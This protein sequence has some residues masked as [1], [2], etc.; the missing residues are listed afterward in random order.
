MRELKRILVANRG[1]IACRIMRTCAA[2]GIETVAVWSEAD[3]DALHVSLADAAVPIGPAPA[4]QSYLDQEK[5]LDAARCSGAD[6][7]HPGYGFLSESAAFARA[8]AGSGLAWIGPAPDTIEAMG[9]KERARVIARAVGV[10]V[11]P[12][13]ERIA[14][15]EAVDPTRIGATIG[16]PLLVKAAAGGGGIGM[17]AVADPGQLAAQVEKTQSLAGRAFTD[18]TV[19]LE[20]YVP[21]ARH[22]EVQVF[23]AGDGRGVHLFDRDCTVQRRFQKVIEEAPAP[24]IPDR[25]RRAMREAAIALVR[26]E[27]YAGA[28]TVEFI[29]DR[30]RDEFYF[31][32][33]NTRIQVEHAVSEMVTGVDLVRWQIEQAAGRFNLPRQD[34]LCCRGHALECRLY[35][36]RPEKNFLPSPG[37]L[38]QLSFASGDDVR[39]DS[40]VRQGDVITPYY[41]PMIAKL[42]VRGENRPAAIERMREVLAQTRIQGV[43]TNLGFL[44][45]V[46]SDPEFQRVNVTTRYVQEQWAA[47][48]KRAV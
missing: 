18:A 47:R 16:Y 36:E 35:A 6:A 1:E 48:L 34:D 38:A 10:P 19:Y 33:M 12:G 21:N 26:A 45:D 32:E 27:R 46:L 23:G 25:V 7:I 17:Q 39:V 13:S 28:G 2:M 9:D 30:D 44:G 42:I 15:G 20:R 43:G 24:G 4:T 11:L 8:V 41:D 5:L 40:G 31:L 29:F 37:R 22:V 14:P 3:A